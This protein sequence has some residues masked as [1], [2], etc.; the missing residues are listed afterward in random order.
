MTKLRITRL[1][2]WALNAI[3]RVLK[4]QRQRGQ[5]DAQREQRRE[6]GGR[7]GG[8]RPQAKEAEEGLSTP[9]GSKRRGELLPRDP[10]REHSP[11]RALTSDLCPPEL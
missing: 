2:R 1:S 6:D 8:M 10:G 9:R 7:D 3:T 5:A 4:G 11:A